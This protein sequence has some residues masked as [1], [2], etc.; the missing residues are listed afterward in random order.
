MLNVSLIIRK[1]QSKP[2]W[3]TTSHQSEW[4]KLTPQ[5]TDVGKDVARTHWWPD[6]HQWQPGQGLSGPGGGTVR[7]NQEGPKDQ[8]LLRGTTS[9]V[10]PDGDSAQ[11]SQH[12]LPSDCHVWG[13]LA[14]PFPLLWEP[15]PCPNKNCWVTVK[16]K[17]KQQTNPLALLLGMQT[18]TASLENSVEFPQKIKNRSTLW[19]SNSTA[20]NLPK[21]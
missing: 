2:H 21:G 1:D 7:G 8:P 18:G 4:L 5:E 14:S 12:L 10:L 15:G 17:T 6:H 9:Y 16:N 11:V 19:P 13:I 20:W 3:D